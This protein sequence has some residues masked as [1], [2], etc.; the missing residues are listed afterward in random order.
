[1]PIWL[2]WKS[3]VLNT[4]VCHAYLAELEDSNVQYGGGLPVLLSQNQCCWIRLFG[5]PI[6]LCWHT[7][8]LHTVVRH[9]CVA[10]LGTSWLNVAVWH[11]GLLVWLRNGA[12][13]FGRLA[14][15]SGWF[16]KQCGRIRLL[17]MPDQLSWKTELP[18]MVV[19]P[20][21]LVC[22]TTVLLNMAVW[23][24][25]LTCVARNHCSRCSSI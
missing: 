22:W 12:A 16:G 24:G 18:N 3:V 10:E 17:G 13:G 8:G 15:L 11:V 7:V 23:A 6:W 21:F 2:G 9:A 4:V 19:W 20:A 1:M 25:C 14:Y 5:L